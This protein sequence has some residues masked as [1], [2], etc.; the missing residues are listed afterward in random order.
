[1]TATRTWASARDA[2]I[3]VLFALI[4]AAFLLLGILHYIAFRAVLPA[5]LE[6]L[7]LRSFAPAAE[8]FGFSGSLPT[9]IHVTAF[10][11]LSCAFLRPCVASALAAG[12]AW[13]AVNVLWELSCADHQ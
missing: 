9:L 1:M 12:A 8:P 13:A 2:R 10:S 5:P 7:H 6:A 11:L 3:S 4:A